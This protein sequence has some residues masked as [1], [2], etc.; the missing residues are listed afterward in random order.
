MRKVIPIVVLI[1]GMANL[2]VLYLHIEGW[3]RFLATEALVI[4]TWLIGFNSFSQ[5]P[6][7]RVKLLRVF[8]SLL[9]GLVLVLNTT[10]FVQAR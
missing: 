10:N 3:P 9:I 4:G 7:D 8:F 2:I 6:P 5:F 1:I